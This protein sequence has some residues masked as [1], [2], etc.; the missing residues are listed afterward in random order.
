[1]GMMNHIKDLGTDAELASHFSHL[2][3]HVAST[4]PS[5]M[6]G[7]MINGGTSSMDRQPFSRPAAILGSGEW[8]EFYGFFQK[9]RVKA[10]FPQ[11]LGFDILFPKSLFW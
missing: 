8:V 4:S 6:L 11:A 2:N 9:E 5:T 7:H 3:T 1:M 10:K